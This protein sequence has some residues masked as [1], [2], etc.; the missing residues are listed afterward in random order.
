MR[1]RRAIV[2]GAG[3]AGLATSLALARNGHQVTLIERDPVNMTEAND[4]VAWE[5]DGIPH[6]LQP[7]TFIARGHKE[8]RDHF[9]DVLSSLLDAGAWNIDVSCK[10][11]GE[12]RPGDED[13]RYRDE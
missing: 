4:A 6:F 3:P 10:L 12:P 13:L 11:V 9:P 5:R 7:H 8:L 1:T 2:L